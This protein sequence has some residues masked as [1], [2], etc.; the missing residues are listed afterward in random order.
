MLSAVFGL[1][2]VAGGVGTLFSLRGTP[3]G[4]HRLLK[5]QTIETIVTLCIV[6]MVVFGVMLLAYGLI[7]SVL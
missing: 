5:T 3:A 6:L 4:P 2:L 7:S 1:A